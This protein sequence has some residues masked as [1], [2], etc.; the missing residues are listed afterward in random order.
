M[1][2]PSTLL[3]TAAV[4]V[5]P[6]VRSDDHPGPP[7]LTDEQRACMEKKGFG[8]GMHSPSDPPPS[9]DEMQKRWQD[10]MQAAKDCGVTGW[11]GPDRPFGPPM[12]DDQRSCM[13]KQGFHPQHRQLN[14]SGQQPGGDEK[15]REAF[16]KAATECGMTPRGN[17]RRGWS[18]H[19][20]G[21][22]GPVGPNAPV[23]PATPA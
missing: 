7:Q 13:D 16:E 19:H 23:G 17:Q 1:R 18:A 20:R 8:P 6:A 21:P 15:R 2:I 3:L 9:R 10:R 4:A 22:I 11:P 14:H 12:N 5:L